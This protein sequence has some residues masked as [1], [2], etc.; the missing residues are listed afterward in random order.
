[1]LADIN[2]VIKISVKLHLVD[3]ALLDGIVPTGVKIQSMAVLLQSVQSLY[4]ARIGL[5]LLIIDAHSELHQLLFLI[6]IGRL[7]IF[8]AKETVRRNEGFREIIAGEPACANSLHI[9]FHLFAAEF[10]S[11]HTIFAE[12]V[13]HQF[14]ILPQ[15]EVKI[16]VA[17]Y[18][19]VVQIEDNLLCQIFHNAHS[20]MFCQLVLSLYKYYKRIYDSKNICRSEAPSGRML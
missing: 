11:C 4:H 6:R 8:E 1:M 12:P 17:V 15:N 18:Q 20:Y 7:V 5:N 2:A 10:S 14:E 3:F 9:Y 16:F 13:G 19:G